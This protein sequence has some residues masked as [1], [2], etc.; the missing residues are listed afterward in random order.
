MWD[1]LENRMEEFLDSISIED[2][3][4]ENSEEQTREVPA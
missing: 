2:L 3:F 1:A 4:R